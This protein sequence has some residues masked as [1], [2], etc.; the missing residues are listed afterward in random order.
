MPSDLIVLNAAIIGG[1]LL[2]IVGAFVFNGLRHR[3]PAKAKSQS[4]KK[5]DQKKAD[6]APTY[7]TMLISQELVGMPGKISFTAEATRYGLPV[8]RLLPT[9]PKSG[10]HYV[11]RQKAGEQTEMYNPRLIP[12]DSGHTP[13]AQ[14]YF[15]N[16]AWA[17]MRVL[18][19]KPKRAEQVREI[20]LWVAVFLGFIL[21]LVGWD[22]LGKIY[23]G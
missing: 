8:L 18:G 21:I 12:R 11:A 5:S 19:P 14:F 15:Q 17:I 13:A 4:A 7:S 23:G 9:M 3:Q 6:E 10:A 22:K 16:I 2:V 1:V 20:V